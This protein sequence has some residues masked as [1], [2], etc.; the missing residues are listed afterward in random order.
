MFTFS[1]L[2]SFTFAKQFSI[3]SIVTDVFETRVNEFLCILDVLDQFR[4][5]FFGFKIYQ[6]SIDHSAVYALVAELPFNAENAFLLVIF[7]CGKE[8]SEAVEV[9]FPKPGIAEFE[10]CSVPLVVKVAS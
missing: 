6:V 5:V 2:K 1:P 7:H 3:C 8:M 4:R 9:N 10:C